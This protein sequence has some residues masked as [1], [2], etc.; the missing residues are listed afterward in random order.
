M[1]VEFPPVPLSVDG[2]D[3]MG[4][5]GA[6]WEI[7]HATRNQ[8]RPVAAPPRAGNCRKSADRRAGCELAIH[9]CQLNFVYTTCNPSKRA[10]R[11]QG[12]L[13]PVC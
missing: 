7:M 4:R 3:A 5:G 11:L 9:A 12:Q 13:G 2:E 10:F 8:D 6:G 1:E